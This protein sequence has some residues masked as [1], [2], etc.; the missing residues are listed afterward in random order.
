V[1]D[2]YLRELAAELHTL[3][4]RGVDARRL[5]E[6]ARDHLRDSAA[7]RG[8]GEAVSGFGPARV[9]AEL[10]AAEL[11]TARTR[12]AAVATFAALAVG[13]AAYAALFLTLS[14]AKTPDIFGGSVPGLGALALLGVVFFPQLAF[15]SGCLAFA[16]VV[17]LRAR[18]ALPAAEL[19]V[20]RWRTGVALAAGML[21]FAS[22]LAAALDF[23]RDLASWWVVSAIVVSVT[24]LV[25]LSAVAAR[26]V[27]AAR[28]RALVPGAA[29][30]VIDD[31]AG[32]FSAVPGLRW[33]RLPADPQRLAIFVAAVA[34]LGVAAAGVVGTDPLD[35][36]L[37]ACAEA[38]AVLGCYAVLGRRLGL[39]PQ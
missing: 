18:G 11:A 39:R 25:L 35:G 22:F 34:A 33:V 3:R 13:G 28:P 15:V 17:R 21:T 24:L 32:V 30:H 4:V 10:V 27:H 20:Q 12:S 31:L 16:R 8:Q 5:L 23:R 26:C 29:E 14:Y 7:E 2:E 36:L 37:R 19:R 1:I 9:L 38:V 6:E